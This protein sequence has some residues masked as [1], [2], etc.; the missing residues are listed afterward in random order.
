MKSETINVAIIDLYNNEPNQ[1]MRCI[2]ELVG[3]CDKKIPGQAVSYDIYQTRYKAEVPAPDYD[4]YISSGG[5][6][7]PFDGEGTPWEKRYFELIEKIWNHN[8]QGSARKKYV[9]FICHSF[10]L[11]CRV[12]N[13]GKVQQRNKRSFGVVPVH[14]TG[15]GDA[16]VLLQGLPEPYFA[17]DF[18]QFEVV[19][20]DFKRLKELDVRVL[21]IESERKDSR[22]ERALMALRLSDEFVGTQYHPEAD[23]VS[24]FY[25]FRQPDRKQQ[26]MEEYG[27]EKY[28]EMIAHLKDPDNITLTRK[29]ILPRFLMEAIHKIRLANGKN[30]SYS[31]EA[32]ENIHP[33]KALHDNNLANK[34]E[35]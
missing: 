20:P 24:M 5:P 35:Q 1:G 18:R 34:S 7:S 13:L 4:I 33:A 14:K 26:V 31:P 28:Y 10:Q 27:E 23:P 21:S 12:F 25:H 19:E 22:F 8:R 2:K 29:S 16:D 30:G 15:E 9:F 6:G 32:R 3:Q 17:A 11:M